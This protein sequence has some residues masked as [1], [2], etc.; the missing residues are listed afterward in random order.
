MNASDVT[1]NINESGLVKVL[2][3][4]VAFCFSYKYVVEHQIHFSTTC[5][6]GRKIIMIKK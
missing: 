1:I 6:V 3:Q 5:T 2:A 4:R